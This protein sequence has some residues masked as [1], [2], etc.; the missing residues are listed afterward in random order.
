MIAVA[1]EY[2]GMMPVLS[3]IELWKSNRGDVPEI[4][5][6][7]F[8]LDNA[9]DR[10]VKVF[11]YLHDVDLDTGPFAFLPAGVSRKVCDELDY[12]KVA[13]VDRLTD[14]QVYTVASPED[15]V[16]CAYGEGTVFF[17][18]T[19]SCLHYGSRRN[20]KPRYVLMFQYLSPCR[21]DFR[22]PSMKQHVRVDDSDARKYLLD[23]DYRV[24]LQA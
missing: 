20:V 22:R 10:Q 17:V 4:G 9:D 24:R 1:G 8:H 6:Q 7:L 23:I 13:G 18:D 21:A 16:V 5:S 15:L 3:V 11:M 14:E 19:I 12:G 2:L